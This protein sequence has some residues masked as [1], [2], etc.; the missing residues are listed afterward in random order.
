[1]AFCPIC[2]RNH[3]PD[4]N[5]LDGT[6]QISRQIGISDSK[7]TSPEEFKKIS[8]SANKAIF[9]VLLLFILAI[10]LFF[11]LNLRR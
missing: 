2:K 5:C 9:I 10:A 8:R 11:V 1:M 3:D 6:T 7:K 4:L